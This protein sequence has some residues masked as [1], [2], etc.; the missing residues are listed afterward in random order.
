[1]S[2]TRFLHANYIAPIIDCCRCPHLN[3]IASWSSGS[4]TC[5]LCVLWKV[6]LRS[7]NITNPKEI[8]VAIFGPPLTDINILSRSLSEDPSLVVVDCPKFLPLL[9]QCWF[10]CCLCWH[11]NKGL[12]AQLIEH[13][14][15]SGPLLLSAGCKQ[16]RAGSNGT[17]SARQVG[18]LWMFD[19]C[20]SYSAPSKGSDLT[21]TACYVTRDHFPLLMHRNRV[22]KLN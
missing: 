4:L 9:C 11:Y 18:N 1:M 8:V 10:P 21:G 19:Q 17:G 14:P 20:R 2:R 12:A 15:F 5:P 16:S 3:V 22:P 6:S 7:F 13:L